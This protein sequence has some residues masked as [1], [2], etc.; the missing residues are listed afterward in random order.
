[1]MHVEENKI[2]INFI[3]GASSVNMTVKVTKKNPHIEDHRNVLEARNLDMEFLASKKISRSQKRP[4]MMVVLIGVPYVA[5]GG[6]GK[7]IIQLGIALT[8]RQMCWCQ[9]RIRLSCLYCDFY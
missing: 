1:M 9:R 5:S 8:K 3:D 7:V 2:V 4:A 6:K